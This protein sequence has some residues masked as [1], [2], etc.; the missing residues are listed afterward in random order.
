MMAR[1]N[2]VEE[3]IS[4]TW[5]I[6]EIHS[7]IKFSAKH[8]AIAQVEGQFNKFN[9]NLIND[10]NDLSS[11]QVELT[12]E[13]ESVDTGNN[14]RD[15][16]LRSDDFFD[17][18]KF[19]KIKFHST[20]VIKISDEKYKIEGDLTIKDNTKPIELDVTYGGQIKDPWGNTRAGFNV[21]G[22]INRFEFGLKWNKLIET[23]GAVV[24]KNVTLSCDIEVVKEED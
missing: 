24:G 11:S 6:D 12:I 20:S 8:M 15:N 17:V 18:E 10:G 22:V 13:A 3:I 23:G 7:T 5:K 21:K 1:N 2:S 4:Q 14:D 16:H 9:F 19:P